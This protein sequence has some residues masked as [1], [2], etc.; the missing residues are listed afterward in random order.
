MGAKTLGIAFSGSYGSWVLEASR[1]KAEGCCFNCAKV[2]PDVKACPERFCGL[3]GFA[4]FAAAVV[5]RVIC[6][7]WHTQGQSLES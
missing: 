6:D 4:Q 3:P 1:S 7:W 2:V 5:Q